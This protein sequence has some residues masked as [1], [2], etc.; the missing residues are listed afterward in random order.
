[1]PRRS[2]LG[3]AVRIVFGPGRNCLLAVETTFLPRSRRRRACAAMVTLARATIQRRP[4]WR[5][6]PARNPVTVWCTWGA[7]GGAVG[8]GGGG[9]GG[10]GD[11]GG[12]PGGGGPGGGGCGGAPAPTP[13]RPGIY[14]GGP[15]RGGEAPFPVK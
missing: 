9:E 5:T 10:G 1:M 15:P 14:G 13:T 3:T 2:R 7:G 12:G 4:P 11:G 8:G 6:T